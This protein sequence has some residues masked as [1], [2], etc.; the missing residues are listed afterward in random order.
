[1]SRKTCNRNAFTLLELLVVIVIISILAGVVLSKFGKIR[2]NGWSTQCKANLRSLYQASLNYANDNGAY[3]PH[4][5]PYET[6]NS[7]TGIWTEDRA[8]VN[9]TG[10]SAWPNSA[11]Q[12]S[13]M[14]QPVWYGNAGRAS[15]TNGTIWE[16]SGH[17]MGCYLCPKFRSLIQSSYNS[18]NA[19]YD[20]VRSYAMNSFFGCATTPNDVNM[21]NLSQEASRTL[22]YADMPNQQTYPAN[23]QQYC[24]FCIGANG[25][26]GVLTAG[27]WVAAPLQTTES[28]GYIHQMSG[29]YRGHV[30]FLDGHVEAIGLY[31]PTGIGSNRTYDAC[32]GQY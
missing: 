6:R 17:D 14:A 11:S 27:P 1:M 20:V 30:V 18:G 21:G 25:D 5:G 24:R 7:L 32:T 22:M 8:W 2:E 9:W 3:F 23:G 19:Q 31:Q 10:I 4:A 16:Y 29:E 13:H 15:I 26:D 28:I 12:A